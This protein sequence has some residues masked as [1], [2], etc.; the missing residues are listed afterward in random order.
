[1]TTK[2]SKPTK[3]TNMTI[4]TTLATMV[5]QLVDDDNNDYVDVYLYLYYWH[6]MPTMH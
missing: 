5:K 6:T 4:I 3:N 2:I 1:M